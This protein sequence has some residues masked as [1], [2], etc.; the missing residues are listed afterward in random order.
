MLWGCVAVCTAC[1]LTDGDYQPA[2]VRDQPNLTPDATPSACLGNAECCDS[3]PCA[4]GLSCSAGVCQAPMSQGTDAGGCF[5]SDCLPPQDLSP[6]APPSSCDDGVQGPDESDSDCGGVCGSTCSAGQSCD[7]NGDCLSGVCGTGARCAAA[8]C[9]DGVA[10]GDE[11]DVDCG[12]SCARCPAGRAC[13]APADCLSGVCSGAG[14]GAGVAQCC[15]APRCVDG[16]RNGGEVDID[17]GGPCGLCP[18]D[19]QCTQNAQCLST[20]CQDGRCEDPGTCNDGL[21]NGTE[22]STDCGGDRCP[23][24]ADRL[25]CSQASDCVNNNCFN[26]VCISCGSGVID[27]SETDIDC[28]GSDPFCRRCNP[29]ERCLIGSDCVS[30]FCNAGVCG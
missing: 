25:P 5:G 22:S 18:L 30:G 21:L 14:C 13:D 28:G 29:L 16:V 17:C 3:R 20:F 11:L 7:G 27:G 1:T 24:C 6:S 4:S 12:G 19:A 8:S 15:Q 10:N 9:T 2:V 26:N 23:R